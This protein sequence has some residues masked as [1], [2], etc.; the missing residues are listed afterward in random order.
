MRNA[1]KLWLL[2]STII[3]GFVVISCDNANNPQ[4][5]PPTFTVTF[6]SAGGST[7]AAQS[8]IQGGM[9][10]EP[11]DPTREF[12]PAAGLYAFMQESLLSNYTFV[13][14]YYG[15]AIYDFST[16]ITAAITLVAQWT[17]PAEIPT[18]VTG[19]AANDVAAAL[20]HVNTNP[21]V[22]SLVMDEHAYVT[23]GMSIASGVKLTI[24]GSGETQEIRL[25]S[26]GVL[27]EVNADA[28]LVLDRNITLVGRSIDGNGGEN[29]ITGLVRVSGD[30]VMNTGSGIS[31]NTSAGDINSV[32][33]MFGGGVH[34]ANGGTFVMHGGVI[35]KNGSNHI[36]GASGGGGVF[37]A[38][39]G[40][41]T[42][43]NG[44]IRNN[45]AAIGGGSGVLVFSGAIFRMYGG[46]IIGNKITS[47]SGGGGVSVNGAGALFEMHGGRISSNDAPW[48]GGVSVINNG[49]FHMSNGIIHGDSAGENANTSTLN[50]AVLHL[51]YE[52]ATAQRGTFNA[53]GVFTPLGHLVTTSE[54]INIVNGMPR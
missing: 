31:G 46:S 7:V 28:A 23:P 20:T 4:T 38:Y 14:W 25:S 12:I 41:F 32:P 42:M 17:A 36:F 1:K 39:G 22:F 21:G 43:Y 10:A 35:S 49:V 29:N 8:V 5:H 27:F 47:N 51:Q 37:V 33:T 52:A 45:E 3:I 48:G 13:G 16:P 53:S 11:S 26:N 19:V 9:A 30:L 34:V 15:G 44:E 54:T 2:T 6:D 24:I 18:P 50:L 40:S